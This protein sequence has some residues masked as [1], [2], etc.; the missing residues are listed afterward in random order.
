MAEV[1]EHRLGELA[2]YRLRR[3]VSVQCEIV[4]LGDEVHPE[5]LQF[6]PGWHR[7]FAGVT[8]EGTE[9]VEPRP[10]ILY[11]GDRPKMC[12]P[13][14][15]MKFHVR[16]YLLIPTRQKVWITG[17]TKSRRAVEYFR[18]IDDCHVI[19][20]NILQRRAVCAR[21]NR[22]IVGGLGSEIDVLS[23]RLL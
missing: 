17:I 5:R 20:V 18:Q 1:F 9:H 3:L 7:R 12:Q 14:L 19:E 11:S 22:R 23:G 21:C 2:R 16:F 4:Y 10:Q 15:S 6:A 8:F 13:L